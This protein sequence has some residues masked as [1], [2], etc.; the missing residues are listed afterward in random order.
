MLKKR[1]LLVSAF[2]MVLPKSIRQSE[3]FPK[4]LQILYSYP[5]P[6]NKQLT[7]N[8]YHSV[9]QTILNYTMPNQRIYK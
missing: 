4:S 9:R 5:P 7:T 6:S 8:L 2:F 1:G 3:P